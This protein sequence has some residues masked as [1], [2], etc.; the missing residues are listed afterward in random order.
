MGG[1]LRLRRSLIVACLDVETNVPSQKNLR[2]PQTYDSC[3]L[4]EEVEKLTQKLK[5]MEAETQELKAKISKSQPRLIVGDGNRL[6]PQHNSV[7]DD[8]R[9]VGRGEC[10]PYCSSKTGNHLPLQQNSKERNQLTEG[11]CEFP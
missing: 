5:E 8:K 10:D 4:K 2:P 9:T 1:R 3:E 11:S 7:E 6:T